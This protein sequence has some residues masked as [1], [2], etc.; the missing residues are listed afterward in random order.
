MLLLIVD[1]NEDDQLLLCDALSHCSPK[2]QTVCTNCGEDA[3][4][5]LRG[6]EDHPAQARP[7][8]IL[9]DINM[10]RMNGFEVLDAIRG[11]PE[12]RPIPVV[13]LTTSEHPGDIHRAYASGANSY[14]CKPLDV[15]DLRIM[16]SQLIGYWH[17]TVK[18]PG[19]PPV[20][21]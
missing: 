8:L 11:F 20:V 6:A 2:V 1:D 16:A 14:L 12:T 19:Q 13:F 7:D 5:Y 17:G 15:R 3:L 21:S 4:R 9:L 10:P 18:L